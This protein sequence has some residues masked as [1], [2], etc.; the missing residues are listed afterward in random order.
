MAW[1][2]LC[3]DVELRSRATTTMVSPMVEI[4]VTDPG[5]E[6]YRFS[7]TDGLIGVD[8]TSLP[9]PN[10]PNDLKGLFAYPDIDVDGEETVRWVFHNPG[11]IYGSFRGRV[12]AEA[13]E[14]CNGRD[15]DCDGL[16]DEDA[17]CFDRGEECASDFDCASGNCTTGGTCGVSLCEDTI[18]NGSET[19]VDCGGPCGDC[20]DGSACLVGDDCFSG[21]CRDLRCVPFRHPRPGEVMISEIMAD[22]GPTTDQDFEWFE[23]RSVANEPVDLDGCRIHTTAGTPDVIRF[24]TI[25]PAEHLVFAH[26]RVNID[27][28]HDSR[29][30]EHYTDLRENVVLYDG[31]NLRN[32]G[33]TLTLTC[34]SDGGGLV[35]IDTLSYGPE[36]VRDKYTIQVHNTATSADA[37]DRAANLCD[38]RSEYRTGYWGTPG[39]TNGSCNVPVSQCAFGGPYTVSAPQGGGVRLVVRARAVGY[40]DQTSGNDRVPARFRGQIGYGPDN[41]NPAGNTAWTWVDVTPS[42]DWID[43]LAAD[44][45]EWRAVLPVVGAV[46][47]TLETAARFT[48]SDGVSW[49]VCSG[50]GNL[51]ILDRAP[52][53]AEAGDVVF[54]EIM[55]DPALADSTGEWFELRNV[56]DASVDLRGCQIS[57][58][59]GSHTIAAT[60]HA[61]VDASVVFAN[62]TASTNG[63]TVRNYIYDGLELD[64]GGGTLSLHCPAEDGET[65]TLIDTFSW[66]G[67]DVL[68]GVSLQLS[69]LRYDADANDDAGNWCWTPAGV[70]FG[71]PVQRGTPGAN[72]RACYVLVSCRVQSPVTLLD[73]PPSTT[74]T[75][76][77]RFTSV[78]LTDRTSGNDPSSL[79]R[80]QFGFG[81]DL[82]S[83]SNDLSWQW[84]DA[85]YDAAWGPAA[86]GF[87]AGFDQ[88]VHDF[89]LPVV[90]GPWDGAF[91][92]SVDGGDTWTFCDL[93]KRGT[94]GADGSVDGYRPADALQ[95][96]VADTYTL[97]TC[98]LMPFDE[99]F[100]VAGDP[101]EIAGRITI[102]GKTD[103]AG[104]NPS[105]SILA[106]AGYG[107][108]GTQPDTWPE[109]AW[110][111]AAPNGDCPDC[112]TADEYVASTVAPSSGT[113]E[114]DVAFRF[115][116]D[117]GL[118]WSTCD[119]VGTAYDPA[120]AGTLGVCPWLPTYCHVAFA[121]ET[122]IG[123]SGAPGTVTGF[124][125]AES[126]GDA[127]GCNAAP[128][129]GRT[130]RVDPSPDLVASFGWGEGTDPLVWTDWTPAVPVA[131]DVYNPGAVDYEQNVDKYMSSF[132]FPAPGDYNTAYRFSGDGGATWTICGPDRPWSTEHPA[133]GTMT[134][135]AAP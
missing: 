16:V 126:E 105:P 100:L 121:Q 34:P 19:D 104:P 110:I 90:G 11:G 52:A 7:E 27:A 32:D 77:G 48:G 22:P 10:P 111:S 54:T 36:L 72:N 37:N 135:T 119:T 2:A 102:P 134:V 15:D 80:F 114:Y 68:S 92:V 50:R 17:G 67:T 6:G 45:D 122:I 66:Q 38:A 74:R 97:D 12:V 18:R 85:E 117:G 14:T 124:V 46:G 62:R 4:L 13:H 30:S 106:Q 96:S 57:D 56:S 129:T 76:V 109:D 53:P 29:W 47:T 116:T 58:G 26:D 5:F 113:P 25:A 65:F 94:G 63:P 125:Y 33:D 40:T 61:N 88:F 132:S 69:P 43:N 103:P 44:F 101:V 64:N 82:T 89:T 86:P 59:T 51:T 112:G 39:I 42:P 3:F 70:N 28:S 71:T 130:D 115:S 79:V 98:V 24:R 8:P 23:L 35:T 1:G 78:G 31:F 55:A 21:N 87:E 60:V 81:D 123:V 9:G 108:D 131:G 127:E 84:S 99:S 120:N 73:T 83:P 75:V 93:D 118:S 49:T 91:R 107:P 41:S 133:L 95:I 20:L 128:L